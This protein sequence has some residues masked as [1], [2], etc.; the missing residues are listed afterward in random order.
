M[1]HMIRY[2]SRKMRPYPFPDDVGALLENLGGSDVSSSS[3]RLSGGSVILQTPIVTRHFRVVAPCVTVKCLLI[4]S[5]RLFDA[6]YSAGFRG[7]PD[8]L[9][10]TLH[11][12][13]FCDAGGL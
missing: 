4:N 8:G 9:V 3:V 5:R 10:D 12:I 13:T 7:L 11:Q 2:C 1:F 6:L